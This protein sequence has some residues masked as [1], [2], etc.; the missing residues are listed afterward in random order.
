MIPKFFVLG[1][2]KMELLSTRM[3]KRERG[4]I[5]GRNQEF[6]FEYVET[7]IRYKSRG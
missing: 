6:S 7:S 1:T 5:W 2:Q 3:K 4:Q